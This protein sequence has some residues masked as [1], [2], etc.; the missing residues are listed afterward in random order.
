MEARW[1]QVVFFRDGL[2]HGNHI[3]TDES[4]F[5]LLLCPYQKSSVPVRLGGN[6]RDKNPETEGEARYAGC[7]YGRAG[8]NRYEGLAIG[9]RGRRREDYFDHVEHYQITQRR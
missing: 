6:E 3:S 1:L 5:E 2:C 8:I 7:T 4:G 9:C